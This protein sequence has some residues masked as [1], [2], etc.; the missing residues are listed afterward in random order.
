M[1]QECAKVDCPGQ[2]QLREFQD[3]ADLSSHAS[4]DKLVE[5]VNH[6]ARLIQARDESGKR[7][8]MKQLLLAR[9]AQKYLDPDELETLAKVVEDKL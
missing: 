4:E 8:R 6:Y 5:W 3:W 2:D 1:C 9:V 7:Y